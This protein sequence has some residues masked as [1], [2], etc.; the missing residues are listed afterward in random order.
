M[1]A[2]LLPSEGIGD[3][4]EYMIKR[5]ISGV[6]PWEL[7]LFKNDLTPTPATVLA[8]LTEANFGG[9]SRL[10]MTRATWTTPTVVSGCAHS[11]WDTV[12]TVW[13]VTAGPSQTIYGYAYVDA[14]LGVLRFIQR[15]DSGDIHP[16]VI[17]SKI[18]LLPQITLTSAEC[19]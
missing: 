9:Y 15:F 10:T 16:V 7:R 19:A 14:S 18:T 6:L 12:A 17:G 1:P 2:G 3:L 11:N 13:D 4:L 8:D 5:A